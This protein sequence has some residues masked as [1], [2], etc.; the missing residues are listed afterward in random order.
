MTSELEEDLLRD[1]ESLS[2]L[3]ALDPD[4]VDRLSPRQRAFL[5]AFINSGSISAARKQAHV[6]LDAWRK[7][8]TD[9]QFMSIY[10][11][12]R[13][14]VALAY[15]IS[16]AIIMRAALRHLELL[17]DNRVTVQQWA[18]ERAYA[19][20]QIF[21]KQ[22][23]DTT[24]RPIISQADVKKLAAGVVAQLDERERKKLTRG[25]FDIIEG[26]TIEIA[27]EHVITSAAS[28]EAGD[29]GLFTREE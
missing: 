18:I 23:E 13:S 10:R 16:Q 24:A 19:L 17:G 2:P 21:A 20:A 5:L 22:T 26:E 9:E 1:I 3:S 28:S 27:D 12:V 7:W 8:Q 11:I 6:K 14:P 25:P 4:Q 15:N 29:S